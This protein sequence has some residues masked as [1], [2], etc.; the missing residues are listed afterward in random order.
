LFREWNKLENREWVRGMA[1]PQRFPGLLDRH[2]DLLSRFDDDQLKKRVAANADLMEACA[3]IVFHRAARNLGD[4]APSENQ[5]INPYVISL[6][7]DRW[8]A[9][10]L[11]DGSGLSLAEARET[12][13]AGVERMFVDEISAGARN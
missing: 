4:A 2:H 8:S 7:P 5:K 11:F 6:D 9:D 3:V 10:G 1:G 12:P 13:A